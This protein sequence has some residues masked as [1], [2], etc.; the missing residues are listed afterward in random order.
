M[1]VAPLAAAHLAPYR[2]LMLEAYARASDAFTSTPE[3]RA[4]APDAWWLARIADPS[5]SSLAFGAF[6]DG[7][8]LVGTVTLEFATKPKTRH[9]ALLIGMYVKPEARGSGA[10][11]RL[12]DAALAQARGRPGVEVVTLTVTQGNA[13]AE[14]LY[15]A[16]GFQVFGIEPM[17]IRTDDG[18]LAKVHMWLPL[19]G[20]GT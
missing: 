1:H 19:R 12:V 2:A 14:A 4:A 11:R 13:P 18:Y 8:T 6:D 15:R 7:G 10:G 9:K 20:G 3:E 5:G 17:A 16:A